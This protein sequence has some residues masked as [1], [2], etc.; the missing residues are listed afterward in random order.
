[1]AVRTMRRA[2][3]SIPKQQTLHFVQN[4]VRMV[5]HLLWV[6]VAFVL[7]PL[8]N[9]ILLAVYIVGFI[10]QLLSGSCP[11]RQRK[12]A[13]RNEHFYPKTV[14]VTGIDTPP[15]LAV[16][17]SWYYEGHR[18]VG[19]SITDS[20]IRSGESMSRTLA[21]FYNISQSQ[22]ILQL[23]DIIYR[24]KVDVWIP[25][26]DKATVME[27][28]MAKEVIE[29]RTNCKCIHLDTELTDRFSR[30]ESFN[31]YLVEKDL[32]VLETHRVQSRASIHSILHRS[33]TKVYQ[34]RRASSIAG[35]SKVIVLP[36][37]TLSQTYTE[38]SEI[39]I[40]KNSPWM[41]QQQTRLG[42]YFA[43]TLV[44]RGFVEAIKIR[45][46]DQHLGWGR[47]RLDEALAIAI[48]KLMERFAM[49]GGP[50][51]TGLLCVKLMVDEVFD[52]N[53]VRHVL[54]IAGCT[55]GAAAVG[56]LLQDASCSIPAGCLTVLAAQT[57]GMS[58]R[59]TESSNTGIRSLMC[60][61][62]SQGSRFYEAVKTHECGR[63]VL[64]V[65]RA[66]HLLD[67]LIYEAGQLVFW[68]NWRYSSF[69]PFP[70]WWDAHIYQP[71]RHFGMAFSVF[72]EAHGKAA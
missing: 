41:L 61:A 39:Q 72:T 2:F 70:W 27:D 1:M 25:C 30:P 62:P 13:L 45:P 9:A 40:S 63:L 16:A 69:D 60:K 37:R 38:V 8:D 71:G 22:Y 7:L 68:K 46:S 59:L 20:S 58:T 19:V 54:H 21:A 23:L 11:S 57:N 67:Q 56:H 35:D 51:L 49:K 24:E 14:L 36:K 18:V 47:S 31:Q 44:V 50:R 42:T 4:L 5:I 64:V 26:S 3:G 43:E 66:V 10:S 65:S 28:A 55:Q 33:P 48:H 17:R 34:M 53:S 29:S 32:P 6:V 52:A 15:G 12:E